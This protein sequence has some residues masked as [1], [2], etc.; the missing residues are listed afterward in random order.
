MRVGDK[1]RAKRTSWLRDMLPEPD[2]IGTV[3]AADPASI[4]YAVTVEFNGVYLSPLPEGEFDPVAL[5]DSP[6]PQK[7]AYIV[8]RLRE[9]A[10]VAVMLTL[11]R[12]GSTG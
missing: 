6:P 3:V 9:A 4:A 8:H 2:A 10:E 12:Q 11:A 1:V 7:K 5:T